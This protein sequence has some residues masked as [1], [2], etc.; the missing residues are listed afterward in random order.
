MLPKN[1]SPE[2]KF[3]A[4]GRFEFSDSYI[5]L[6]NL[7]SMSLKGASSKMG[8]IKAISLFSGAGGMD[9]GFLRAGIEI[10]WA[11]DFEKNACETYRKNI[12]DHIV[13][14]SILDVDYKTL[15][16][17]D[18]VFGGPP[19]QGFSV[20]GKMDKDDPRSKLIFAFQKVVEAKHPRYF[21]ME[22]VAAL[23]KLEK[24]AEV[25]NRLFSKYREMGYNTRYMVLDSSD[26]DTPQKRERM[27]LIG[28]TDT[29]DMIQF[30]E[31]CNRKIS[32][33]EALAGLDAPGTGNNQGVCKAKITVAASP[34][35]RKSQYAGMIF[36][37]MGRPIDLS[38]P[39]QTLPASMGGNKTPIIDEHLLKDENAEDWL[40]QWH[41]F[42]M[43]K[44][45]FDAYSI[46][47]PSHLRRI[48]V[49]EA[50]RLQGF[51]DEYEFF[52]SQCHKFKQIGNSV[53]P[54]F[55]YHV[56]CAVV[57]SFHGD[58]GKEAVQ[59]EFLF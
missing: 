8:N 15:P 28:T 37:G 18:L 6:R 30:P 24:F 36:N 13:C 57:R 21:V 56:A 27:I 47:V 43:K 25:R 46:T 45:P 9:L 26:Y 23:A 49:S 4:L 51:P 35:L 22:N 59:M 1:R 12:G 31:K 7:L 39:S 53:P 40:K 29:Y 38:R 17:C 19:C 2:F 58:R 54:P 42:I 5:K 55:A 32:A 33:R 34:I 11:N 10:V 52:G 44:E 48:T 14:G 16:D 50:A 3:S 41:S 20:A